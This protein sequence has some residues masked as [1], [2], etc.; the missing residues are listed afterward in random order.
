MENWW[1]SMPNSYYSSS[2]VCTSISI[3]FRK[4]I[5]SIGVSISNHTNGLILMRLLNL[6]SQATRELVILELQMAFQ[7]HGMYLF[8]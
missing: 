2:T 4:K 7:N 1:K 3:Q 6:T 5:K 8:L